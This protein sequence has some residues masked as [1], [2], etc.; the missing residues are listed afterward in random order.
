MIVAV[1]QPNYIPWI[2][3]FD[4]MDQ[5]HIFVILDTVQH[6]RKSV[7]HRNSI[8]SPSGSLLLSVPIQ[9]KGQPINRL[10]IHNEDNWKANHWKS[11][12]YNYSRS[13]YWEL[14]EPSFKQIY[15]SNWT[16]LYDL[17]LN[18]IYLIRTILQI[19]T[20]I[21]IESELES[22]FEVGSR[23][24]VNICK[25][26]GATTY[27]SGVGA[28][29]YNDEEDFQRNGIDLVYQRFIHP[30]YNQQWG[31]FISHLSI[32]DMIFNHGPHAIEII[33]QY[34]NYEND[35]EVQYV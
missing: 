29:S 7:T 13:K 33:R 9:N 24:I 6:S 4:K 35:S 10:L 20:K 3:F 34:R 5:S 23:R 14:Y 28:K 12:T 16:R 31:S 22:T 19:E 21:V 27:L 26:L 8:K 11:I 15:H 25:N 1:H 32:L 30:F 2:G 17:N 18:L